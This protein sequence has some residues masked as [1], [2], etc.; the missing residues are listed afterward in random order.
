MRETFISNETRNSR[1]YSTQHNSTQQLHNGSILS[2]ASS[3]LQVSTPQGVFSPPGPQP[4][5]GLSASPSAGSPNNS[6]LAATVLNEYDKAVEVDQRKL[7]NPEFTPIA[8]RKWKLA[9][10]I[11]AS[12]PHKRTNMSDA[13]GEESLRCLGLMF[14]DDP[15]P[16]DDAGFD[17]YLNNKFLKSSHL[18]FDIKTAVSKIKLATP[19]SVESLH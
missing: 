11:Y 15:V 13:F 14:S 9:Y 16:L 7:R 6:T 18:F 2:A 4:F 19:M 1:S 5:N 8:L 12:D 3:G 10:N 17:A